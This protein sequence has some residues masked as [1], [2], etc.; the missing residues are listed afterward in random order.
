MPTNI[1]VVN[2]VL[3][4]TGSDT[5]D[6]ITLT[7][8]ENDLVIVSQGVESV[9]PRADVSSYLF[10]A[11]NGDD[12]FDN[13]SSLPGTVLGGNGDDILI[14]GS[15]TDTIR[16]E[17]GNDR[18]EGRGGNDFIYGEEGDDI[19]LGGDGEDRLRSGDGDDTIEGG[20]GNDLI[21]GGAGNDK[22]HGGCLL[23]TS[24]SPRDRQKSRMPSSA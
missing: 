21:I 3:S 14:G 13:Q 6:E 23:Y 17:N 24:P 12:F 19:I 15:G 4:I 11:G 5:R 8:N 20:D 2:G 7:E 9:I 1:R 22:L 18:L 10:R 16:G